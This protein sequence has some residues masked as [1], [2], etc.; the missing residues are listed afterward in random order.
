MGFW[1]KIF[2]IALCRCEISV[3]L[4]LIIHDHYF[5]RVN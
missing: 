2:N 1:V 3:T 5:Y 4:P